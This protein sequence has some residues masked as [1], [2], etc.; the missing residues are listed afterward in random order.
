MFVLP[1][2]TSFVPCILSS[3]QDLYTHIRRLIGSS[4]LYLVYGKRCPTYEGSAVEEMFYGIK[5]FAES[6]DFISFPPIELFPWIEYIPKWLAPVSPW[7]N[8]R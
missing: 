7:S 3:L 1:H 5:L 8:L 4:M 6:Y 2:D